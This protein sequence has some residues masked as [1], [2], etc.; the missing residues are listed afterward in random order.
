MGNNYDKFG[1]GDLPSV[2]R[3]RPCILSEMTENLHQLIS[4]TPSVYLDKITEWLAIYHDQPIS[5][6]ALGD[7][8]CDLGLTYKLL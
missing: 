3:G 7:N 6:T 8:L 5:L 1:H 4:E 2:L